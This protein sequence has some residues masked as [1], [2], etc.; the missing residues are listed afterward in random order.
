L[1]GLPSRRFDAISAFSFILIFVSVFDQPESLC[2][3]II[4]LPV[5]ARRQLQELSSPALAGVIPDADP[6]IAFGKCP[7]G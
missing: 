6:R 1:E 4:A 5:K 2:G 7:P 3:G